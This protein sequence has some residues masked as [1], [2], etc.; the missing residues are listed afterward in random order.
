MSK[1]IANIKTSA[2]NAMFENQE[3]SIQMTGSRLKSSLLRS[4]DRLGSAY[5]VFADC[6]AAFEAA[7]VWAAVSILWFIELSD[8]LVRGWKAIWIRG[9]ICV[10]A[11]IHVSTVGSVAVIAHY[12]V[13][14]TGWELCSLRSVVSI[15]A[16]SGTWSCSARLVVWGAGHF[17]RHVRLVSVHRRRGGMR[18]VGVRDTAPVVRTR[19]MSVLALVLALRVFS[20]RLS[21]VTILLLVVAIRLA[22]RASAC[23]RCHFI[24]NVRAGLQLAIAR[25]SW[26]TTI[27]A[28]LLW[29]SSVHLSRSVVRLSCLVSRHLRDR[30]ARRSGGRG[31]RYRTGIN[32][33][34]NG[35]AVWLISRGSGLRPFVSTRV[36]DSHHARGASG[37]SG[38]SVC[39]IKRGSTTGVRRECSSWLGKMRR[40][41]ICHGGMVGERGRLG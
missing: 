20:M 39:S 22:V 6:S 11:N 33:R 7:I 27:P 17:R 28:L 8:T 41:G 16:G 34:V 14:V 29:M 31:L 15:V 19:R 5:A 26:L 38:E 21:R 24:L 18:S 32:A 36:V 40:N 10:M 9:G 1:E 35:Q 3:W 37:R 4:K 13:K 23:R 30:G 12:A 25:H 2:G